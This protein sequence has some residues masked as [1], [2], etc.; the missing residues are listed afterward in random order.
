MKNLLV[1][2]SVISWTM[3][4][5]QFRATGV[6]GPVSVIDDM[7]FEDSTPMLFEDIVTLM[8]YES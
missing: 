3:D 8:S 5:T 4:N 2:E 1:F 7:T 6:Q